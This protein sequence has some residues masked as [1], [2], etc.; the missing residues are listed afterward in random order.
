MRVVFL[1]IDGVLN[2]HK[3]N[4]LFG[5]VICS[6]ADAASKLDPLGVKFFNMLHKAG[7]T[8]VLS[9]TWRL[10][11]DIE[12][13][14][15][16]VGIPIFDKTCA[17][18]F[19]NSC[20]GDEIKIW[21]DAHPEVTSYVIVDDDSDML[22]EQLPNFVKTQYEEGLTY[23]NM[24]AITKCLGFDIWDLRK[25]LKIEATDEMDGK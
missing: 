6:H 21:L 3:T 12:T 1:D 17:W 5:P 24:V 9:S 18:P 7:I 19:A 11:R 13:M 20:R 2:T 8:I 25:M 4:A 16:K 14:T 15:M 10:G 22:E 23:A